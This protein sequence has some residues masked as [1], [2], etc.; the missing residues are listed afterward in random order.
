[1]ENPQPSKQLLLFCRW[2]AVVAAS[3]AVVAASAAAAA[4]GDFNG[5]KCRSTRAGAQVP[6]A[7]TA[8]KCVS[9]A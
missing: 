6:R 7:S 3:A 9:G 2:I 4:G 1:M 5:H 8:F